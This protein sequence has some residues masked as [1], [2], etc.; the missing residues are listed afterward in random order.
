MI[1]HQKD[2]WPLLGQYFEIVQFWA[3]SQVLAGLLEEVQLVEDLVA[4]LLVEELRLQEAFAGR[5][6]VRKA[7][8]RG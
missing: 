5:V 1:D 8:Q 4:G 6:K 7:M 3:E 2:A